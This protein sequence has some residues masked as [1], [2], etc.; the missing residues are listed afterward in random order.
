MVYLVFYT[1]ELRSWRSILIAIATQSIYTHAGVQVG[2]RVLEANGSK[3]LVG[4][5]PADTYKGRPSK[6]IQIDVSREKATKL[7]SEYD[8]LEYDHMA[9]RLWAASIQNPNK[10]YCFEIIWAFLADIGK[11][12]GVRPKR[13]TAKTLLRK[14]GE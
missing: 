14:I 4:W 11:V 12:T 13:I 1:V 6:R 8:G 5:T 2:D 3:G 7:L 10:F 9:L